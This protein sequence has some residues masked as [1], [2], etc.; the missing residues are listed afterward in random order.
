MDDEGK[1]YLEDIVATFKEFYDDRAKKGLI[2]EKQSS[3]LNKEIY[4][5]KDIECLMLSMPFKIYEEMGVM[6]HSKYI[7]IIQLEKQIAKRLNQEDIAQIITSCK[8][9]LSKYYGEE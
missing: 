9:G 6:S 1:A 2:V 5:E 8:Q 7:G 4:T 3:I